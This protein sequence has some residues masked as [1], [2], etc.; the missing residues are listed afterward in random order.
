M[1]R[2][3]GELLRRS[4]YADGIDLLGTDEYEGEEDPTL[5]DDVDDESEEDAYDYDDDEPTQADLDFI[6]DGPVEDGVPS[7]EE[8][9]FEHG[10][11]LLQA[12]VSWKLT[13]QRSWPIVLFSIP[14]FGDSEEAQD[15]EV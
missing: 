14:F 1:T 7:E 11:D 6:N 5:T 12:F 9:E 13:S 15:K 8:E 4:E 2:D 10:Q 3:V